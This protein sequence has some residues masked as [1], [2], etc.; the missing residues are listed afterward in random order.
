MQKN[1]NDVSRQFARQVTRS[2]KCNLT[3]AGVIF[4]GTFTL[5]MAISTFAS[6]LYSESTGQDFKKEWMA[7]RRERLPAELLTPLSFAVLF[8]LAAVGEMDAA[9]GDAKRF[10]EL[11]I[12]RYMRDAHIDVSN[13]TGKDLRDAAELL[14]ANM[15]Q[16]ARTEIVSIGSELDSKLDASFMKNPTKRTILIAKAIK[17]V[18]DRIDLVLADN[19]ELEKSLLFVL[20]GTKPM[21]QPVQVKEK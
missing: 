12:E 16:I 15:P 19:P 5:G 2:P 9:K 4:V 7:Q 1:L 18:S 11:V 10:A 13:A 8:L 3:W 20:Q 21:Q 6:Y 17:E 14:I